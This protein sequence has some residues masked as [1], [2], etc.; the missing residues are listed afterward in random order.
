M[1]FRSVLFFVAQFFQTAQGFGPLDAGLRMLPWT[2]TLFVFA[3]LGGRLVSLIGERRLVVGGLLLQASGMAWVAAI[4]TPDVPY[5]TLI[6]P[7][8]VAGAGV[9]LAMPAAQNA[10]IDAVAPAEIGK[11][12]GAFNMFRFLGGAFG[13]AALVAVFDHAG[14]LGSPQAFGSGFSAAVA[15]AAVLSAAGGLM[16]LGLPGRLRAVATVANANVRA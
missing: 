12:S 4:A 2:A 14:G 9:S 5:V 1:L 7:M 11:A 8:I 6:V 13:I 10:V 16:G 15:V 3:P